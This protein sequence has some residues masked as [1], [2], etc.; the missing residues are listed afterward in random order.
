MDGLWPLV[1]GLQ[2]HVFHCVLL[3]TLTITHRL[4]YRNSYTSVPWKETCVTCTLSK[5]DTQRTAVT[6]SLLL[7]LLM[8]MTI[9]GPI[10]VLLLF[11]AA[12]IFN[13]T[14]L[15]K[16]CM[17]SRASI[18][19]YFPLIDS[20]FF[21]HVITDCNIFISTAL[22]IIVADCMPNA[23]TMLMLMYS[24]TSYRTVYEQ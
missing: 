2:V 11:Y 3:A 23:I 4:L 18:R 9:L 24:V 10:D 1:L 5:Q 16:R 14:P 12:N 21:S 19:I 15:R 6:L 20:H 8:M 7:L 13:S 22:I 17:W